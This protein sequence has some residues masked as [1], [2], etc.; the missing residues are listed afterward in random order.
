MLDTFI[1]GMNQA[2][3][4][5]ITLPFGLDNYLKP[6]FVNVL[7]HNPSTLFYLLLD[8]NRKNTAADLVESADF[9]NLQK[10]IG[11]K[12]DRVL[13]SWAKEFLDQNTGI[14][15]IH[16]KYLLI[17]PLSDSPI[18]ITGSANF[19]DDSMLDNDENILVIKGNSPETKRVADIYFGEYLRLFDHFFW[20]NW[21]NQQ[22][23]DRSEDTVQQG[24]YLADD[25]TWL[26]DYFTPG[27]YRALRRVAFGI[28]R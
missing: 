12:L 21:I 5:M 2:D 4:V 19:S 23:R 9:Q 15:Y 28:P 11:S 24:V 6:R 26:T 10:A 1:A 18:I 25:N 17:N 27:H 3:L 20:R 22:Q 8:P 14:R 16:T 7:G 13:G